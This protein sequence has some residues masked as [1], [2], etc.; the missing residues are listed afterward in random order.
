MKSA[1]SCAS[2]TS[3]EPSANGR[4][5]A[6][7][8]RDVDAWITFPSRLDERLGRIDRRDA[9]R[10][11]ARHELTRERA[12]TATDVEHLLA[13]RHTGEVGE[14]RCERRQVATHEAV[15]RVGGH[16]ER[17]GPESTAMSSCSSNMTF[18]RTG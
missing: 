9:I 10:T 14:S 18:V 13:D 2:E 16:G 7:A 3:D 8:R 12:G 4:F 1:T 11:S 5:S 17:H 15:V 6:G